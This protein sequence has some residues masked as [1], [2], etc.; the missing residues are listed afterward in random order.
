[1]AVALAFHALRP[2]S[3]LHKRRLAA[4]SAGVKVAIALLVVFELVAV[5]GISRLSGVSGSA[6]TDNPQASGTAVLD[7][8]QYNYVADALLQGRVSLDLP[9][10]SSL[11]KMR[12]RMTLLLAIAFLQRLARRIIWIMHITMASTTRTLAFCQH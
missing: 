10:S 4:R 3:P 6:E 2:A 9:V 5:V 1:M 8:N 7:F 12:I 11:S